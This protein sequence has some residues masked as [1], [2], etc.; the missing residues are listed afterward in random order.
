MTYRSIDGPEIR[1]NK[2]TQ[3]ILYHIDKIYTEYK[4]KTKTNKNR[5]TGRNSN[6]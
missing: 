5:D 4:T 2:E 6:K 3:H 1:R